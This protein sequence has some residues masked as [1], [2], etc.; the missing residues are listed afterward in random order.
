M[1]LQSVPLGQSWH[2][3]SGIPIHFLIVRDMSLAEIEVNYIFS[4]EGG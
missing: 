2:S 1:Q 3:Q 4:A